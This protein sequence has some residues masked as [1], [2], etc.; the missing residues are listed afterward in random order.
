M[1]ALLADF[2]LPGGHRLFF[3]PLP[4]DGWWPLLLL[5]LLFA[6]CLVYKALKLPT[7]G[8]LLPEALRLTAEVAVGMALIAG[9]LRLIG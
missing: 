9:L 5:P 1:T 2:R 3:D 7:L 6:V 4:V 8:R